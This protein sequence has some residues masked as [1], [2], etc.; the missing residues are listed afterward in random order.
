[1]ALMYLKCF[2]VG[3]LICCLGQILIIKTTI[4]SSRI[5]VLFVCIGAVLEGFDLYDPLVNFAGAGATVP[6]TGFGRSLA[7]GVI[8]AIKEKGVLGLFTGGLTATAGGIAAA[9][10]FAYIFSL[11]FSSKTKQS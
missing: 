5:L 2:L 6:I 4:T 10:I 7:K 11:I 3:G 1:M 9:V 8:D